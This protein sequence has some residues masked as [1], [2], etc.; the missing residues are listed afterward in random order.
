MY[1]ANNEPPLDPPVNPDDETYAEDWV[2]VI[3]RL[4]ADDAAADE[5]DLWAWDG[6]PLYVYATLDSGVLEVSDVLYTGIRP[7]LQGVDFAVEDLTE[8]TLNDI[9]AQLLGIA[10]EDEGNY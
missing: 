4:G 5:D 6:E 7:E 8:A 2:E 1:P 3:F 9:K 10:T